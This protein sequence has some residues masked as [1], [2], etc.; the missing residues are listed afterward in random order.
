MPAAGRVVVIGE[1]RR[2]A[3]DRV[4][5]SSLFA[6]GDESELTLGAAELY[7]TPGVELVLGD[8]AVTLDPAARTVTTAAGRQWTFGACVLATGS[9]PFVPPIAGTDAT[10]VFVYRTLDDLAAVK[11]SAAGCRMTPDNLVAGLAFAVGHDLDA[12]AT[13]CPALTSLATSPS[14]PAAP[15]LLFRTF[16]ERDERASVAVASNLSVSELNG[17]RPSATHESSPVS[18]PKPNSG[19]HKP[20]PTP[21]TRTTRGP[22]SATSS[23]PPA[24]AP[25]NATPTPN[26]TERPHHLASISGPK[27]PSTVGPIRLDTLRR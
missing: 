8:P 26:Q 10:G 23:A 16:T 2:R 21:A 15:R 19:Y 11:A 3:Y 25:G 24:P 20:L 13:T 4:H 5:L 14:T 7:D 22:R 18:S 6:G 27:H 17:A 9:V 12:A 1:E